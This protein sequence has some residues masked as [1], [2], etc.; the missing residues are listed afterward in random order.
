MNRVAKCPVCQETFEV[1]R[2]MLC[3]EKCAAI[4]ARVI[5]LDRKYFP[6]HGCEVCWGDLGGRCSEQC[7][8]EFRESSA[9]LKDLWSLVRLMSAMPA[10]GDPS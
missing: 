6:C 8:K 7:R 2:S 3:S 4:R 9:F 10:L 1:A 5:E